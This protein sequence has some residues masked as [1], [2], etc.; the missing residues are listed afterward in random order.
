MR[1]ARW[2][3]SFSVDLHRPS[4][5][6]MT[7][8]VRVLFAASAGAK[9]SAIPSSTR[10]PL[11]LRYRLAS[12]ATR[13]TRQVQYHSHG[14]GQRLLRCSQPSAPLCSQPLP[15]APSLSLSTSLLS[16]LPVRRLCPSSPALPPSLCLW[17]CSTHR[18]W[19]LL[20]SLCMSNASPLTSPPPL[21]PAVD[22]DLS[23]PSTR[24]HSRHAHGHD[25]DPTSHRSTHTPH[26]QAEAQPRSLPSMSPSFARRAA[27]PQRGRGGG[28]RGGGREGSSG[29]PA[30][31]H[32][33]GSGA[34]SSAAPSVL[35][36]EVYLHSRHHFVLS[37]RS[38]A[39][40]APLLHSADAPVPWHDV[41]LVIASCEHDIR[42]CVR[43]THAHTDRSTGTGTGTRSHSHSHAQPHPLL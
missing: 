22:A 31:L 38:G 23:A 34:L 15:P 12:D 19:R 29:R 33:A 9:A 25:I 17:S 32:S 21:S 42:L 4:I 41:E 35:S 20:C 30:H 28:G 27:A 2:P 36:K 37:H 3:F 14:T 13:L 11:L 18:W 10:L 24:T 39:D 16:A 43:H 6:T 5:R 26:Q 1:T 7:V 40:S 8:R